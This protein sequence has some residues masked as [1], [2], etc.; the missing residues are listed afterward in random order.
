M[1]DYGKALV[2]INNNYQ[3]AFSLPRLL[4]I[5]GERF[6]KKIM[7][8]FSPAFVNDGNIPG[9]YTCD[10]DNT[11]P[12]FKINNIPDG[13]KSLVLIVDDPD[14]SAGAWIHW[15]VWNIEP[16]TV[17]IENGLVPSGAIEGLTDFGNIGYG[18]PCS[19]GGPHRYHFKLFALDAKLELKYGA[20]YQ[21][22]DQMMNGHVL[23]RAELVGRYERSSL[24]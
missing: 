7:I 12:P 4:A 16:K 2:R 14:S 6:Q 18:G 20:T 8:I 19:G 13:T 9:Q 21:E 22:L 3:I 1:S 23:A 15:T 17:T 5:G 24:Q 10:G 11:N